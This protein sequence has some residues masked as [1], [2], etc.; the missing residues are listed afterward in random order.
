[1][2]GLFLNI[3]KGYHITA[4]VLKPLEEIEIL[5][6]TYF[7]TILS[8]RQKILNVR[9]LERNYEV[10]YAYNFEREE[11]VKHDVETN[12]ASLFGERE[13]RIYDIWL[14]SGNSGQKK[15][16]YLKES[17]NKMNAN[18]NEFEEFPKDIEKISRRLLQLEMNKASIP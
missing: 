8:Y 18:L 2:N 17:L 3:S 9:N 7:N 15:K 10:W 6:I 13:W 4:S 12:L 5:P 1:V 16:S 14:S 11:E